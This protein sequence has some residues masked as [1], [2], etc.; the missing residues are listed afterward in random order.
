MTV[1]VVQEVPKFNVLSARKYGELE[2]LLPPGQ[3]TLS[4]GPTVNRL[5]HSLRDFTDMDYLLLIGDP[6]AIGLAVAIASNV[7]RGKAMVLKWDRQERQYYPLNV[8]LYGE[9]N[10]KNV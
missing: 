2:L 10:D 8:N 9:N 7:N 3:I 1:Y 6:L 5:K 4:S